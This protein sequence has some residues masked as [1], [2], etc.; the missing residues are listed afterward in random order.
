MS[1]NIIK[2]TDTYIPGWSWVNVMKC[3]YNINPS[4]IP[5]SDFNY[6]CELCQYYVDDVAKDRRCPMT[7]FLSECSTDNLEFTMGPNDLKLIID[8]WYDPIKDTTGFRRTISVDLYVSFTFSAPLYIWIQL[9]RIF[10]NFRAYNVLFENK[11]PDD[12]KSITLI[13]NYTHNVT[14]NYYELWDLYKTCAKY[15]S[16]EC[17]KYILNWIEQLPYSWI[18]CNHETSFSQLVYFADFNKLPSWE[19]FVGRF[20]SIIKDCAIT[21][22]GKRADHK[23]GITYDFVDRTMRFALFIPCNNDKDKIAVF[24]L[25][26]IFNESSSKSTTIYDF[27]FQYLLTTSIVEKNLQYQQNWHFKEV[28][29]YLV[30]KINLPDSDGNLEFDYWC[31]YIN[32]NNNDMITTTDSDGSIMSDKESKFIYIGNEIRGYVIDTEEEQYEI[33]DKE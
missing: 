29:Q 21:K 12:L 14:M 16:E 7:P 1:D 30:D 26:N 3:L 15:E 22:F 28:I 11:S 27:Y 32:I 19:K 4:H 24:Q 17:A 23:P 20:Y 13:D 10:N 6:H 5:D 25:S 31:P 33:V 9:H 8:S 2:I 18:I